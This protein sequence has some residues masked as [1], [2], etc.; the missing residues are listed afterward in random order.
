MKLD[1]YH[2]TYCTNIHP[3]ERWEEVQHSLQT[4]LPPI[5]EALSPDQPFGI[6]LRLSHQATED[7]LSENK[8]EDFREWLAENNYYVFTMNA[9]PYG[10]FHRQRVK[11]V[12]HHP[13]WTTPERLHY[14]LRS[15]EVLA[16]LLPQEMEG[17]I[18]TSPLSY[19][20]WHA[21]ATA[22]DAVRDRATH[23]LAQVATHL[24]RQHQSTGQ[25][26]HLDL[27]PE[28]DGML[29]TTQDVID[30]FNNW[31][32]PRGIPYLQQELG[33]RPDEAE[34]G[35]RTHIRICYD[36]CHFAVG[37]ERPREVFDRWQQAG[38]KV[39]KIQIS[40]ALR[41]QLPAAT[42]ERTAVT[43]AFASLVE[44]TYLHQ[45]IARTVDG[46]LIRYNDL[47][48]ALQHIAEPHMR[49]WR[50]HFH[51]P[52]FVAEYGALAATQSDIEEVLDILREEP[53]TQHLEVE[54]YTWEVLPPEIR[55]GLA[56]S[57][58]R[59]LQWVL[60]HYRA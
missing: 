9:F 55:L 51:V 19:R 8:L 43:Q 5:R 42:T 49:E 17:G 30:Y 25:L 45:V 58:T 44:S 47:P 24:Y 27:E 26:L 60:E 48:D 21:D 56:E 11:D 52:I 1:R 37:Y 41:A 4:Y 2:L 14:T 12:V 6:G 50:T 7:I 53:L 15:F 40:A 3:G 31:L 34:R 23:H 10:G 35:L 13:D 29:E 39:G 20:L 16:A 18:S 57:I 32:L 54:T 38:I 28:P 46:E 36:V 33:V 59:E 22:L